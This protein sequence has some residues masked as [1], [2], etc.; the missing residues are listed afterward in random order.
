[1]YLTGYLSYIGRLP[2][3][4]S[5]NAATEVVLQLIRCLEG[6]ISHAGVTVVCGDFNCPDIE[7]QESSLGNNFW[8]LQ[9]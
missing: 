9:N 3:V 4:H 8:L 7:W 6:N 5:A 2:R 1:M